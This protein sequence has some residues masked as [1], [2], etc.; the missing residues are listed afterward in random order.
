MS[1]R[2]AWAT[3]KKK[4]KKTIPF[5][6]PNSNKSE[7]IWCSQ[8]CTFWPLLQ[9]C[10]GNSLWSC[11]NLRLS[12][13]IGCCEGLFILCLLD[14]SVSSLVKHLFKSVLARFFSL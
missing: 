10:S 14:I 6:I 5:Y 1:L 2:P 12:D 11:F 7:F 13:D 9:E 4:K 8:C 3:L